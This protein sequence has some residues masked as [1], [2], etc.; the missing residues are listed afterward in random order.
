LT[1]KSYFCNYFF[2]I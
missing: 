1:N 2:C